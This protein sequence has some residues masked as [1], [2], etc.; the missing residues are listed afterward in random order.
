MVE[1]ARCESHFTQFNTDGSVFRGKVNRKDIGYFQINEYWNGA[2]AKKLGYDIY[3]EEGNIGFALY[4]YHTQ[5]T[6]P[7]NASKP[8]WGGSLAPPSQQLAANISSYTK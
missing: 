3:T 8:C 7:W 6:A 5:G 2:M 4:L 1:I